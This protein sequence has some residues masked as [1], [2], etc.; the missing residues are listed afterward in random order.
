MAVA[1]ANFTLLDFSLNHIESLAS[2]YQD[3]YIINLFASHMIE[4]RNDRICFPAVHARM[5]SQ[6]LMGV[7]FGSDFLW[8]SSRTVFTIRMPLST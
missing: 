7:F 2:C 3:T 1:T 6:I 4:L 5:I 8:I